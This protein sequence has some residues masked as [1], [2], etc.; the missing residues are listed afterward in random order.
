MI[1]SLLIANRGEIAVRIVRACRELGIRSVVAYSQADAGSLSV[2]MADEGVCIG[3]PPASQSYLNQDAMVSAAVLKKCDAIH[4]GVGFLAENAAFARKVIDAGLIFVGPLPETISMLGDKTQAKR[5]AVKYDVPTVPGSADPPETPEAVAKIADELGF[6]LIVKAAAG[7]GGKGMRVVRDA[8]DLVGSVRLARSEAEK[9]FGDGRVY[10][11]RYLENPRH[12]EVQLL[13]DSHGT[14]IHLGERDCSVQQKHQKLIEESPSPGVDDLVRHDMGEA[15]RRLFGELGYRGA[16]TVEFLFQDGRF[17]FIE[18]NARV[19][20]EHPVTELVSGVDI[21][22]DQIRIASGQKLGYRQ[23]DIEIKG[24][25]L[26]CRINAATSGTVTALSFPAGPGVRVDSY[27]ALGATVPPYYDSLVAKI[28]CW[29]ENRRAGLR[30]MARALEET[31]IEGITTNLETQ[32][33]ILA[34]PEF[35]SGKFGTGFFE[36]HQAKEQ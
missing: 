15:G 12:V 26:E 33:A 24:Y 11:E 10:V 25:A 7:G 18:V 23:Q 34:D 36:R 6:P 9:A 29:A 21:I 28:I 8:K 3:P 13:A 17:Y 2:S 35:L 1:G 22:Q 14:V 4:P 5:M 30:R 31:Q 32:K 20:V 27:L 19:Q 16:G